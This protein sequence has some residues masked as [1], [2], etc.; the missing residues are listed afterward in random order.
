MLYLGHTNNVLH[1][2]RVDTGTDLLDGHAVADGLH[3][4]RNVLVL[5]SFCLEI[6]EQRRPQL[7]L[8]SRK[9][10][11]RDVA[12]HR[13]KLFRNHSQQKV[14]VLGKRRAVDHEQARVSV[15][16]S[17]ALGRLDAVVYVEHSCVEAR[18]HALHSNRT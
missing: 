5:D 13:A 14:G 4:A 17:D 16:G 10:F 12:R 15:A 7:V 8:C 11:L 9:L 18:V 3:L 6:H 2:D 1:G